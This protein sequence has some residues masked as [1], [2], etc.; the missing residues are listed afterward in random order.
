MGTSVEGGGKGKVPNESDEHPLSGGRTTARVVR[1]GSTVR[2]TPAPN[3]EFVQSLLWH[4]ANCGFDGAPHPM[5]HDDAGREALGWIAGDVPSQLCADHSDIV[6]AAAARLIR[7]FHDATAALLQ[8]P[9]ARD[10]GLEV[11]C[12]NDLS[13]CNFVFR[14]GLPVAIIDF[15]AACPGTRAYDLGYAAWLWLDIGNQD[16]TPEHQHR[17]L[18][19]FVNAYDPG[20]SA[21]DLIAG[22]L[23]R[24]KGIATRAEHLGDVAMACW[25]NTCLAWS[26]EHLK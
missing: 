8:A 4:L 20:P 13:P 18:G 1:V 17:R 15:E 3:S 6:L 22:M 25:A 5:G 26:R 7:R 10:A 21:R 11:V 23:L 2:R 16:V 12:H 19:V 14:D 9:A 24:Q